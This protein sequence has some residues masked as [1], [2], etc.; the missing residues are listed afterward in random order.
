MEQ[1]LWKKLWKV[2]NTYLHKGS[3]SKM[4]NLKTREK[5]NILKQD[6]IHNYVLSA[7]NPSFFVSCKGC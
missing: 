1:R 7:K 6:G 2:L 3:T 4:K 5:A